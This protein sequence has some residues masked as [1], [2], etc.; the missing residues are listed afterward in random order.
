MTCSQGDNWAQDGDYTTAPFTGFW[1]E[2]T[3]SIIEEFKAFYDVSLSYSLRLVDTASAVAQACLSEERQE[4]HL[5]AFSF[6][7]CTV[8]GTASSSAERFSNSNSVAEGLVWLD[9]Y[10]C[11]SRRRGTH[12]C[13]LLQYGQLLRKSFAD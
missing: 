8:S 9:L 10:G 12:D 6:P 4:F 7:R 1:P 13:S 2:Y 5:I 3:A 11:A